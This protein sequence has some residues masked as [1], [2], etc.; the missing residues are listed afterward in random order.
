MS[1][2]GICYLIHFDRPYK[3]AKH[4]LG[5]CNYDLEQRL[6]HHVTGQGARLMQVITQA[7]IGF[8]VVRTWKGD[9]HFERRLKRWGSGAQFCP[10]CDSHAH[11]HMPADSSVQ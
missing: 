1:Q 3:H 4:Y 9:R 7:G 10:L 5:Y 11:Q 6:E 8:T 2:I